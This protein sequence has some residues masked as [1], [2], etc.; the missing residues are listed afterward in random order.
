[1]TKQNKKSLMNVLMAAGSIG[2]IYVLGKIIKNINDKK[3]KKEIE[4]KIEEIKKRKSE[5][6]E[7]F[8]EKTKVLTSKDITDEIVKEYM[9]W[10][11]KYSIPKG[12][13]FFETLKTAYKILERNNNINEQVK[14]DL[15]LI[16]SAKGVRFND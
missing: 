3:L 13:E 5:E 7:F 8:R 15:K 9:E 10:L 6:I 4:R 1:M 11:K 12:N 2:A 16:F 14:I